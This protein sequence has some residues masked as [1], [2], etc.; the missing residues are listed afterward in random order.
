LNTNQKN[1][2]L[3]PA[4]LVRFFSGFIL[5][6]LLLIF[7][8]GSESNETPV[9]LVEE[10]TVRLTPVVETRYGYPIEPYD[11]IDGRVRRNQYL[12]DI[13]YRYN[14]SSQTV[15][16]ITRKSKN[17][18]DVRNIR[19]GNHYTLFCLKDSLSTAQIFVYEHTPIEYFVIDLRDSI[20]VTKREKELAS[21][22]KTARGTI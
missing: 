2:T 16:E 20:L 11:L 13:L 17:I 12:S 19:Q 8:G 5:M 7:P 3:F 14:V 9:T 6:L 22:Q 10:D 18:F 4:P 21:V 1:S 15:Q